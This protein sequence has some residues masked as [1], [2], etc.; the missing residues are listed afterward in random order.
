M[1]SGTADQAAPTIP[2]GSVRN[3][4]AAAFKQVSDAGGQV[5]FVRKA[6]AGISN[7]AWN[8]ET[9]LLLGGKSD[10][11]TDFANVLAKYDSELGP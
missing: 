7:Q 2:A 5:P 6:T 4:V 1:P 10:G 9:Q 3:D 11:D 8:P